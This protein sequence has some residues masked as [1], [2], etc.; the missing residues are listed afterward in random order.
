MKKAIQYVSGLSFE[1][2]DE[3]GLGKIS[4]E[5]DNFSEKEKFEV[6]LVIF[7]RFLGTIDFEESKADAPVDGGI[8]Q[9][10][11]PAGVDEKKPDSETPLYSPASGEI[12]YLPSDDELQRALAN[13][14]AE[15]DHTPQDKEVIRMYRSRFGQR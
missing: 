8:H 15:A 6:L 7:A 9:H 3:A 2:L 10:P 12:S 4:S 1:S 11:V 13:L 14:P 5:M